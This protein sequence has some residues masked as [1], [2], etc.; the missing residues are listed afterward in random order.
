MSAAHHYLMRLLFDEE[1][2]E[3]FLEDR[4]AA[5]GEAIALGPTQGGLAPSDLGIFRALD[6]DGLAID[7]AA[8]R[9]YLMSALCRAYPLS[10]AAIGAAPGGARR[11]SAFLTSIPTRDPA[12]RATGFGDHLA[13]LVELNAAGLPAPAVVLLTALLALERAAVDNAAACR[14]AVAAG[15]PLPSPRPPGSAARKQRPIALP[16]FSAIALLPAP[17]AAIAGALDGVGPGDAWHRIEG[18]G[19]ELDRLVTVAR[20]DPQPVT[21]LT[22]AVPA[23]GGELVEVRHLRAELRG[24]K[25]GWLMGLLGQARLHELPPAQQKLAEKLME[26]GLLTVQAG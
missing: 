3:A 24:R 14:A 13:R 8:R 7:A 11:L 26:A 2:R 20:A 9:R 18:G 15:T 10:A 12:A 19:L 25:D 6:G 23:G 21:V 22:R 4:A 17:T 1:L 16:P 5:L